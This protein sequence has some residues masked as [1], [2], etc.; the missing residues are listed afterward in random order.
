MSCSDLVELVTDYLEGA[1]DEHARRELEAH[2]AA[3]DD[4]STY[5]AQMRHTISGARQLQ[6]DD[7]P[8]D[9]LGNLMR[10]FD[11]ARPST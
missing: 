7:I 1:V 9:L 11:A 2:L 6:V 4:C 10:N 3:C 8:S 5:L